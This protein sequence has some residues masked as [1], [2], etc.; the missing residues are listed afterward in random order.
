ML[1]ISAYWVSYLYCRGRKK[2]CF[3]GFTFTYKSA[4]CMR[5]DEMYLNVRMYFKFKLGRL[6]VYSRYYCTEKATVTF[7][8]C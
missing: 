1:N 6:C 2:A 8:G 3:T 7:A 5:G 4:T